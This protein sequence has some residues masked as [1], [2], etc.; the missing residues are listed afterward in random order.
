M[1]TAETDY[2]NLLQKPDLTE[3]KLHAVS[4]MAGAIQKSLAG[5][6]STKTL[7][8]SRL[9]KADDNYDILGYS[10]DDIALSGVHT[11]WVDEKSH[12]R[13]QTTSGILEGLREDTK[14]KPIVLLAK[15]M[16]YRRDVRDR[17]HT[18]EPHQMD[19]WVLCR[20]DS[21]MLLDELIERVMTC[22]GAPYEARDTSHPY[23]LNGRELN[24]KWQNRWLEVGE[25]GI[26]HPRVLE[27]T[28]WNTDEWTGLAMGLGLDRM[29][30]VR[31]DIPDI[32]LLR[33]PHP[34]VAKQ[35]HDLATWQ[36]VSYQ[37]SAKRQIS[38]LRL[39]KESNETLSE[40]VEQ[41]CPNPDIL[42]DVKI[43]SRT[44]VEQLSSS[45]KKRLGGIFGENVLLEI[46]LRDLVASLPRQQVN[47]WVRRL[48]RKIHEGQAWD[49][50]P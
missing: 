9:V 14:N 13:T 7:P 10:K 27:K 50:C 46:E 49:Y 30:M 43:L 24:A 37:P 35:M 25:C 40:L 26:I 29:V 12:L 41:N 31:K 17:T 2:T 20:K 22:H 1:T 33:A 38:V 48:Y 8:G 19:I 42:A 21:P 16:V 32:R 18:G 6:A 15:G 36:E 3:D 47:E 5:I 34:Q 39:T 4:L 45:G 11:K 44:P 23:T 28:G